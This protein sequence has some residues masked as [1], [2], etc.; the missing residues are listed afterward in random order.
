M[1]GEKVPF[2]ILYDKDSKVCAELGLLQREPPLELYPLR[3][4]F[5]VD[6]D[7]TILGLWN[8]EDVDVSS[9]VNR[10]VKRDQVAA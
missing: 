4:T 9:H 5:L 6:T 1:D 2:K 7:R 10:R 3:V 8:D